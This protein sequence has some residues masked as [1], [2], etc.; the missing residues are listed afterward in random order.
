MRTRK[1]TFPGIEGWYFT[2]PKTFTSQVFSVQM[3]R[4]RHD[5]RVVKHVQYRVR[6]FIT[7]IRFMSGKIRLYRAR[8]PHG[9]TRRLNLTIAGRHGSLHPDVR[10]GKY[11]GQRAKTRI[12][13]HLVH[14]HNQYARTGRRNQYQ[15]SGVRT[16]QA[17]Y[18][19]VRRGKS[20]DL[21][22]FLTEVIPQSPHLESPRS[23]HRILGHVR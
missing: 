18:A 16:V 22:Q 2:N 10:E 3:N 11:L 20:P 6:I 19:R 9:L 21:C 23:G 8:R 13:M 14:Q 5:A 17:P 1:M 12:T 4:N 15:I 7:G